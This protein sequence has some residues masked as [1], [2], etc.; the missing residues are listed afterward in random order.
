[1]FLYCVIILLMANSE[2]LQ[3]QVEQFEEDKRTGK[4]KTK[5]GK[6]YGNASGWYAKGTTI[7]IDGKTY[8]FK[9]NGYV[10]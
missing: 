6:R 4:K 8:T 7:K 1:M 3:K 10:K 9:K 5:K 2:E